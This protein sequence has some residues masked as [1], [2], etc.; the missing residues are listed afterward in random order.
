MNPWAPM[1]VFIIMTCNSWSPVCACAARLEIMCMQSHCCLLCRYQVAACS[2]H[3]K[4]HMYLG[5]GW[6]YIKTQLYCILFIMLMTTCFGHLQVTKMYIEE[7]YTQFD[8]SIGAYSKLSMRS[9]RL[10][11]TYW[12]NKYVLEVESKNL[13]DIYIYIYI[14]F[15]YCT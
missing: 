7:N 12:A 11:Y 2:S 10:V 5:R 1:C 3:S 13:M 8:H 15:L 9:R 6:G 4:E 14:K